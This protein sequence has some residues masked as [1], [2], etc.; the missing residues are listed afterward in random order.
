MKREEYMAK[1]EFLRNTRKDSKERL[2][3][4]ENHASAPIRK[5]RLS[6][7]SKAKWEASQINL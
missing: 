1:N 5:E 2:C 6:P 4:F 3:D 7:T